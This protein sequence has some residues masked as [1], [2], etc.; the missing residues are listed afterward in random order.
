[1]IVFYG[2]RTLCQKVFLFKYPTR[3]F[4]AY[5][6]FPSLFVPYDPTCDFYFSGHTG[7]L[8]ILSMNNFTNGRILL[9]AFN[10]M[11]A[12]F[13]VTL[14]MVYQAHYSIDCVVGVIC[15]VYAYLLVLGSHSMLDDKVRSM[16]L[17]RI[18]GYL[19][20]YYDTETV[21][22]LSRMQE[23][24]EDKVNGHEN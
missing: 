24:D 11:F 9:S 18:R 7:I 14:L 3:Y 5:P 10:A 1:M 16:T 6:G 13:M 20:F 19:S 15:A 8:V 21:A 17:D 12:A 4:W 2:L 23:I 22:D